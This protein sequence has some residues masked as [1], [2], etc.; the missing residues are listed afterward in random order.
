M[1]RLGKGR[2]RAMSNLYRRWR[3]AA[4]GVIVALY[5]ASASAQ[6]FGE[7]VTKTGVIK[8]N[9]VA[10]GRLVSIN[11]QVEGDVVAAGRDLLIADLVRGDILA[12]G[13]T[14]TVQGVVEGDVRI[15]G[16]ALEIGANVTGDV[17]AAGETVRLPDGASIAGPRLARRT[18]GR[19]RWFD[20]P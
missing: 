17:M 9:L 2:N 3:P 11:A 20:R 14:I 10:A 16:R 1:M 19:C 4:L 7:I 8:E 6:D 18:R 13:E 15:A 12:A 5:A